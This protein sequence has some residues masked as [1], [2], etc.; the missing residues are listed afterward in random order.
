MPRKYIRK[1]NVVRGK[2]TEPNL[3]MAIDLATK[4]KPD[5][6]KCSSRAECLHESYTI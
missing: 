5:L 2:W 1:I 3:K 4:K 6:I